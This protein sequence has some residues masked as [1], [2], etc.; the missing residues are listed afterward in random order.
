MARKDYAK[1]QV[2]FGARK[3]QL[4]LMWWLIVLLLFTAFT[5]G[6][7]YLSKYRHHARYAHKTTVS[8]VAATTGPQKGQQKLLAAPKSVKDK[9]AFYTMLPSKQVIMPQKTVLEIAVSKNLNLINRKKAGLALLGIETE[10]VTSRSKKGV[11]YKLVL[12]PFDSTEE[13]KDAQKNLLQHNVHS[14]LRKT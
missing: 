8:K 2:S 6:L 4:P 10:M 3:G 9:Y 12:G 13:A 14:I 5:L 11:F 1:R 7:M